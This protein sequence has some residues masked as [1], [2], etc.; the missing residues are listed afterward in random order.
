MR[1]RTYRTCDL[2][3]VCTGQIWNW[4]EHSHLDCVLQELWAPYRLLRLQEARALITMTASK[5]KKKNN[6]KWSKQLLKPVIRDMFLRIATTFQVGLTDAWA[7]PHSLP[8]TYS[9]NQ[10]LR[11][12]SHT[13]NHAFC[14]FTSQH[15]FRSQH[16]NS[17]ENKRVWS[18][19]GAPEPVAVPTLW[20]WT[21]QRCFC[22]S[23]NKKHLQR[24]DTSDVRVRSWPK[25]TT[26]SG[27]V[28]TNSL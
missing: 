2:S 1:H 10:F 4:V 26:N 28:K 7:R 11:W 22:L 21:R 20:K 8:R 6:Y 16:S 27:D 24:A 14:V 12:S 5:V 3:T 13:G 19:K 18:I 23:R 15:F 17:I 25:R 9:I